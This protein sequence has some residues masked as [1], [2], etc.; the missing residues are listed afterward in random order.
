MN[1]DVAAWIRDCQQCCR[2]KV[3]SQPAAPV[4]PIDVPAK[5]FNHVHMDLVGPLPVAEDGSTYLLTMVDGTTRWLEAVPLR[6]MEAVA[7]ADAFIGTWVCQRLNIDHI[8]MTAY[9]PQSNGMI[10]R[11]HRQLQDA[12]RSR[13]AG[14]QW[15]EHL[16]WVLMG[17]RAAPKKESAVS[18]AELVFG[19]PLTLPG[20]LLSTPETPVQEVVEAIRSMQPTPTRQISYAEAASGLQHLQQAEFVYVPPLSPL[21]QGPYRVLD[22]REKF[23]KLEVRGRPEVVSTDWLKPHLG[24][25]PVT[26]ASPPQR[27]RPKGPVPV[28]TSSS[29][30]LASTGGGPR[31]G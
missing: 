27:G 11:T 25:A 30:L 24:T 7:C 6:S 14:P 22:R 23:F 4:Q 29:T 3:K 28:A 5:R 19:V 1:S 18:S 13:L 20:Q 26:A 2:G 15:P 17:L 12:L 8:T 10:D 21:Y 31:G 16:P 9:H